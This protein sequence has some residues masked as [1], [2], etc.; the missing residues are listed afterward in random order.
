MR[1]TTV[2]TPSRFVLMY[3]R[4][5]R[6]AGRVRSRLLVFGVGITVNA[7]SALCRTRLRTQILRQDASL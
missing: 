7:D 1:R 4:Q 2:L 5:E 6:G 3:L